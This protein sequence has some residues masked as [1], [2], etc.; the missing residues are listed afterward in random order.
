MG[1]L[2]CCEESKPPKEGEV[3]PANKRRVRFNDHLIS[4]RK[5]HTDENARSPLLLSPT[6]KTDTPHPP[7]QLRGPWNYQ[8]RKY[9]GRGVFGCVVLAEEKESGRLYAMKIIEKAKIREFNV[10]QSE[11]LSQ[12]GR[13]EFLVATRET[14]QNQTHIY[15]VMEYLPKGDLYYYLRKKEVHFPEPT[16]RAIIAEI[17]V[18]IAILH[19]FGVVYREL[20]PENLLV[21]EE[22]HIKLTDYGF[23]KVIIENKT[24]VN[25]FVGSLEYMPP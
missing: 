11:L 5:S 17:V 9:L 18:G 25:T 6:P 21:T 7:A 23:S 15:L 14:F 16:I 8:S 22:G 24:S 4:C 1:N 19:N 12:M 3:G 10:M 2:T 20:K 13:Q